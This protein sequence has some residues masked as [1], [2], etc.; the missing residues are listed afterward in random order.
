MKTTNFTSAI[1]DQV[2]ILLKPFEDLTI[3]LEMSFLI[4]GMA[5]QRR[6]WFIPLRSF[7]FSFGS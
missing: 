4:A 5:S 3:G 2:I 1:G 7:L 6:F